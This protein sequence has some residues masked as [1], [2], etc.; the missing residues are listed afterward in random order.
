MGTY[1]QELLDIIEDHLTAR[2]QLVADVTAL[3]GDLSAERVLIAEVSES[4]DKDMASDAVRFH[5]LLCRCSSQLGQLKTI[6]SIQI[7]HDVEHKRALITEVT[8]D[9]S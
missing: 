8:G 7:D 9:E 1:T 6:V 4:S 3:L 5:D 2:R